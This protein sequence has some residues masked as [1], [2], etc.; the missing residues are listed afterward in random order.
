VGT[1]KVATGIGLAGLA[2]LF[3]GVG[4]PAIRPPGPV[5]EIEIVVPA[6]DDDQDDD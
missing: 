5:P 6:A 4:L 1:Q 3:V 2:A